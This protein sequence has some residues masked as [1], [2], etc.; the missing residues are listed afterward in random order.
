MVLAT[1]TVAIGDDVAHA[2]ALPFAPR[3]HGMLWSGRW[4]LLCCS[5]LSR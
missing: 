3:S 4:P 1:L 5:S 2:L